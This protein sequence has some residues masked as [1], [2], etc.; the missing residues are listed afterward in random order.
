M[1]S[2]LIVFIIK[3]FDVACGSL[4]TTF[5]L[6]ERYVLSALFAT[7]STVF[8]VF[9]VQ[10]TG[11]D[12]YLA[13]ALATF[14]GNL[15]PPIVINKFEKDSLYVFE[16]TAKFEQGTLF[17][18]KLRELNIAVT[19]QKA[20]DTDMQRVLLVKCYS[21]TKQ[22]SKIILEEINDNMKYN[23]RKAQ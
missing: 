19:T 14:L 1:Q 21:K 17:A 3:L 2:F 13:I 9:T 4:K 12:A 5:I 8:F 15:I 11:K 22:Q 6:K 20:Y 18:D 16:I 23:I 10:Q 7:L